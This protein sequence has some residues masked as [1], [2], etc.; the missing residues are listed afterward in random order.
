MG[1]LATIEGEKEAAAAAKAARAAARG[2]RTPAANANSAE[3]QLH[4]SQVA[5]WKDAVAGWEAERKRLKDAGLFMLTA[6][7]KPLKRDYVGA[8]A[9]PDPIP[10][11][12][13]SSEPNAPPV[14]PRRLAGVQVQYEESEVGAEADSSYAQSLTE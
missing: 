10:S 4:D 5:A 1:T 7:A 6:G 11:T 8:S 12:S 13:H 9:P 2:A 14:R 3:S